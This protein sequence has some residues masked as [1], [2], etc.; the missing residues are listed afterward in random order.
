MEYL[1]DNL[2]I[3]TDLINTLRLPWQCAI[4]DDVKKE[5]VI[6]AAMKES[7]SSNTVKTGIHIIIKITQLLQKKFF[8][9]QSQFFCIF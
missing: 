8:Y 4:S 6:H 7:E 9:L 3:T 2:K 1:S 5:K